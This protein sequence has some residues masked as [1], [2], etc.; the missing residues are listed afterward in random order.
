MLN[1]KICGEDKQPMVLVHGFV[2]SLDIWDG[3]VPSLTSAFKLICVD[4]P[5]H[6]KSPVYSDIHSMEFM[7]AEILKILDQHS[8]EKIVFS[9]HSMGG[10]VGLAFAELFPERLLKLNLINSTCL[11][12][13]PEKRIN[14]LK[15][16][17]ILERNKEI[18]LKALINE[19]FSKTNQAE[20]SAINLALQMALNT[21]SLGIAAAL[22]GMAERSN[23]K[24]LLK[25]KLNWKWFASENDPV[26]DRGAHQELWEEIG[27]DNVYFSRYG[28]MGPLED[29]G[30]L[31]KFLLS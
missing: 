8:I 25:G 19:L 9:G 3:L 10:Y 2:G 29:K 11:S 26:L 30:E 21:S 24:H 14:R 18:Y 6:G 4:L 23:R 13:S 27:T 20:E 31:L 7:A 28:H 15:S 1:Y 16:I 22:R 5:G 12:D 17:S